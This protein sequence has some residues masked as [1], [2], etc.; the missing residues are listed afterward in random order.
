VPA[1]LDGAPLLG[2]VD[3]PRKPPL[4]LNQRQVAQVVAANLQQVEGSTAS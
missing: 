1:V 2:L 4:A 3:Q